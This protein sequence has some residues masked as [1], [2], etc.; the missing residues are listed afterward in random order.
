[1]EALGAPVEFV[2]RAGIEA[3]AVVPGLSTPP[4]SPAPPEFRVVAAMVAYNEA[5]IVLDTLRYLR[6][7]GVGVYF[8]D[9]WSTD[10]TFELVRDVGT[11]GVIG[12]ERFPLTGPTGTYEWGALLGRAEAVVADLDAD[13]FILHDVD[14]RRSSPWPGTTLRDGVWRVQQR[15]FN[16]IDHTVI[17]FPP[18]DN[19]Y[20]TGEP[21]EPYF[22]YFAP[23]RTGANREQVKGWRNLGPVE[24]RPSGGHSAAFLGRRIFP[25]KF[26]LKHYP[27]RSQ[28]HGE[29]KVLHDRKPRFT[30]T[31]RR[32][33]SWHR[34]YDHI[35]DGHEFV[36]PRPELERFDECFF[37]DR[38]VERLS[39][40]GLEPPRVGR[41][42]PAWLIRAAAATGTTEL[43]LGVRRRYRILQR[44]DVD[45]GGR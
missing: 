25:Y 8:V 44:R 3:L 36:R 11:D 40:I 41:P 14:E 31:E 15:G 26:L 10:G 6:D 42:P 2:G 33:R 4:D 12:L 23:T 19:G 39:G 35:R 37:E 45:S 32:R 9:N 43:L 21:L 13:W 16:A 20:R 34:H 28:H 22:S 18:T 27:I 29:Q 7:S 1:L 5:D 38:L 17:D 24:L 30:T